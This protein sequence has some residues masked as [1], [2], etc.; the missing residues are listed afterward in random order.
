MPTSATTSRMTKEKRN[1][2][3]GHPSWPCSK[4]CRLPVVPKKPRMTATKPGEVQM[5]GRK[6]AKG[7]LEA[8]TTRV[9]ENLGAEEEKEEM[10]PI[11]LRLREAGGEM[12]HPV[13][14]VAH[15]MTKKERETRAEREVEEKKELIPLVIPTPPLPHVEEET[16][17]APLRRMATGMVVALEIGRDMR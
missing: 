17:T 15:R 2:L 14:L 10:V 11:L 4:R 12:A 13:R 8:K 5:L 9:V 6:T 1:G 7:W 3:V 16:T